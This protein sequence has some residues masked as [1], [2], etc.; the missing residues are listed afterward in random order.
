MSITNLTAAAQMTTTRRTF[1]KVTTL[2]G[3]GFIVGCGESPPVTSRLPA[4]AAPTGPVAFNAFVKI[5]ADNKVTAIIKHLDKGQG[6]TTGLSTLI[7]EELDAAWDQMVAEF[8]PADT[9][10]YANLSLGLQGTGGSSSVANSWLQYRKAAAAARAMLVQAAAAQWKVAADSIMVADGVLS[11]PG[12]HKATFGELAA[13]AGAIAPPAEP[14]LKDPSS[15]KLIGKHVPRLDSPAKTT[16]KAVYTLDKTVPGML[17]AVV[18]HAPKFGAKVASFDATKTRTLPGVVDV[19]QIP[20]GVA[21]LADGYWTALKGREALTVRWDESGAEKRGSAE[22]LAEY[23]ALAG[24][25]GLVALNSGDTAAA[26]GN[27]KKKLAGDFEFPYLAHASMEPMNCIVA[28]QA[29]ECEI[30]TGSQFQTFDQQKAAAITGLKLEQIKIN[31]LFAGGSFGRRAVPD[32]DY[33]AEA[34][35]IAKAIEGR[36][37]VK[38]Q[39][40]REDDMRAGRYRPMHFHRLAGGIDA[41]G[42]I[43]AWMQTIIGQSLVKGTALEAFLMKDGIDSSSVEGAGTPYAI[44]NQ[45]IEAQHPEVGVPVLWWRSVGHT[46]TA[47]ATEVFLDE[48]VAAAGK[49]PVEVRRALLKDHPRHLGVLNLAVE[50]AGWGTP[51]PKG[52]GRGVA[53]HESFGSFVAEVAEVTV[54][55]DGT[56]SVDRVV[57]AVD[58]GIAVN[59]DVVRAQMEGGIGYGLSAALREQITLV[60]GAVQQSNFTDYLALR[61]NEMPVVEVHIVPSTEAPSGVGEPGLPPLAPAVANAI[62]S[63]TGK[64]IRRLPLGERVAV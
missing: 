62:R 64:P 45:R 3:A 33:I 54:K 51:L 37:P 46:H 47:F 59:P 36:A 48:L 60:N 35:T 12:G 13:A 29:D 63:V 11:A 25:P 27:A 6:I 42:D 1:I 55:S 22:L 57:C 9:A 40:S 61:I 58:C 15:F 16:G 26:L 34:V 14:T 32:S 2:A 39:W 49:D 4:A 7:A 18:A 20:T 38:L 17:V 24:K 30:W 50:K 28:L 53:V 23:K 19:V 21:V 5:G 56:F 8:A 52:R 31:T 10:K 43:T 44:P 41:N